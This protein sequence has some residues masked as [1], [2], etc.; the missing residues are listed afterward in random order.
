MELSS[1]D[2]MVK[3][4]KK[5]W[6]VISNPGQS[7]PSAVAPGPLPTR[8]TCLGRSQP[9]RPAPGG[10]AGAPYGRQS[11]GGVARGLSVASGPTGGGGRGGLGHRGFVAAWRNHD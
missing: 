6:S 2:F 5:P 8:S 7:V 10:G 1:D 3:S 11:G 9:A 4:D